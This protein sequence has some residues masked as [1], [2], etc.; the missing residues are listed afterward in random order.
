MGEDG[1]SACKPRNPYLH[2]TGQEAKGRP[3]VHLRDPPT[4]YLQLNCTGLR[5]SFIRL[6]FKDML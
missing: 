5:A 1:I 4:A 3:N 2:S 6:I